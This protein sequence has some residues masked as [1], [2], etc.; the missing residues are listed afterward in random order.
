[1]SLKEVS[2]SVVNDASDLFSVVEEENRDT[3][4]EIMTVSTIEHE[5]I[6]QSDTDYGYS[7]VLEPLW[8]GKWRWWESK[9]TWMRW[10]GRLWAEATEAEATRA[11]T[12]DLLREIGNRLILLDNDDYAASPATKYGRDVSTYSRVHSILKYLK[13]SPGFLTKS[14]EWDADHWA[15]NLENGILD[16]RDISC[17]NTSTLILKKHCP[18]TLCTRIAPVSFDPSATAEKWSTHIGYFIND[19]EVRREIQRGLGISLVGANLVEMLHIWFGSGANGKSTT[20]TVIQSILGE[21][22]GQA[23]PNLLVKRGREEHPTEI[24]DLCGKRMVFSSETANESKLDEAKV[25]QLT[26]GDVQKARY[27]RRDYFEFKQTSKHFLL[28]NHKP[29]IVGTDYGIWRRVRLIPWSGRIQPEDQRPQEDIVELLLHEKAGILNWLIAG[30]ADWYSEPHWYSEAVQEETQIYRSEQD[31]IRDFLDESCHFSRTSEVTI[32]DLYEAY[33]KWCKLQNE[34]P[35]QKTTFSKRL[36]ARGS[37]SPKK[38]TAGA[39]LW[40]GLTLKADINMPHNTI[41][42]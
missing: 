38:G 31:V 15:L 7:K 16:L 29:V 26:G 24:A 36:T 17:R 20:A 25:K 3:A 39:R 5:C 41:P 37:I 8:R 1:M 13:G 18:E 34:E 33:L 30:L 4:E 40:K 21:Y 19:H 27:M 23:A 10:N 35:L 42:D 22:A 12:E 11:A 14:E 9:N 32:A 28:C 6:I 2:Y